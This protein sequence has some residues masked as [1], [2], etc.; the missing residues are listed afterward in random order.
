MLGQAIGFTS[1]LALVP[2]FVHSWGVIRF[3]EWQILSSFSSYLGLLD[4]GGQLFIVNSMTKAFAVQDWPA[5][6]RILQSGLALFLVLP[7]MATILFLAAMKWGFNARSFGIGPETE[8]VAFTVIFILALQ[9]AASLPQGIIL[10]VY[11][12]VGLLPMGVMIGNMMAAGQLVLISF[13][14]LIG[15]GMRGIALLQVLPYGL[16]AIYAVLDLNRRFPN[17]GLFDFREVDRATIIESIRPSIEFFSIQMATVVSLQSPIL[18]IGKLLGAE[19]VA[20]FSMLRTMTG[21]VRQAVGLVSHSIWPEITRLFATKSAIRFSQ[22][23]GAMLQTAMLSTTVCCLALHRFGAPIFSLWLNGRVEFDPYLLDLLLLNA[24]ETAFWLVC[25]NVLM[26]TNTHST[27]SRVV[28]SFSLISVP[29]GYVATFFWGL[30]GLVIVL[31]VVDVLGPLWA[32]PWQLHVWHKSISMT[33]MFVELGVAIVGLGVG[34]FGLVGSAIAMLGL[35]LRWLIN[36][37]SGFLRSGHEF[38]QGAKLF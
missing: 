23:F 8:R 26:A 24:F 38:D 35:T 6:K 30:H 10:G 27:Y 28:I 3:G 12:A 19:S 31:T 4:L 33:W 7:A 5:L 14:L 13:G 17:V 21:V 37:R 15:F 11:R 29:C 2:L 32:V 25:G 34:L 1:R 18:I 36:V 16:V 20:V 22:L 9:V